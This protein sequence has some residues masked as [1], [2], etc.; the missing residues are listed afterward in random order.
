MANRLDN[1]DRTALLRIRENL[2]R[3]HER[4]LDGSSAPASAMVKQSDVAAAFSRAIR[5]LEEVLA[6]AGGVEF[7]KRR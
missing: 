2:V 5:S 1:Q 7:K 3:D 6:T 4:L